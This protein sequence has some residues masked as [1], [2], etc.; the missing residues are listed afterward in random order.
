ME[1]YILSVYSGRRLNRPSTANAGGVFNLELA[2]GSAS[3]NDLLDELGT[4][5]FVTEVSGPG[6]NIVTGDY[7]RGISGFWV[8]EGEI[9]YPVDE[10]TIAGNL[11]SMF[12]SIRCVGNDSDR[13]GKIITPSLIID[14]MMVGGK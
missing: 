2:P 13:R 14:N 6:V 5:L 11:P 10:V 1:N 7:S 9:Q 12:Q 4:G 3:F 8:E